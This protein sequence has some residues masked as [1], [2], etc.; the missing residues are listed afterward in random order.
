MLIK[1]EIFTFTISISIHLASGKIYGTTLGV[2]AYD[3]SW[4]SVAVP[5]LTFSNQ[6]NYVY[7]SNGV[8]YT[9]LGYI[10][11]SYSTKTIYYL[12]RE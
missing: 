9:A 3:A 4:K 6:H 10:V 1:T 11:G 12:G 5:V 7:K 8:E 2:G